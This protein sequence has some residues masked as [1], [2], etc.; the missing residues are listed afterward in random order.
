MNFTKSYRY[1]N[2]EGDGFSAFF[3]FENQGLAE[4]IY[5]GP[6]HNLIFEL[7]IVGRDRRIMLGKN[8]SNL[9]LYKYRPSSRYEDFHEF[10]M[11]EEVDL[12]QNTNRFTLH[13]MELAKEVRNG[14]P[15]YKNW[16]EAFKT[17][18]L[19]THISRKYINE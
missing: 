14:D 8:F 19:M 12:L 15:D 7:D 13:L 5:C 2:K 16:D 10:E 18:Q 3:E 4:L 6:R 11:D 17:Q 1:E 9:K